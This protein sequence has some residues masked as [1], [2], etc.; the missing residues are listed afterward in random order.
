MAHSDTV[1]RILDAAEELFAEH[2]FSETSLRSITTQA[3]VNLAAVNYHFGSKKALI[4]AVFSRYLSPF[5]K[6]IAGSLDH[7]EKIKPDGVLSIEEML[8]YFVRA[9]AGVSGGDR[10]RLAIFMRLLGLAYNQGQGH[11]RKYLQNEYKTDYERL[12]VL[13]TNA[14][15]DLKPEE[16]FWRFHFMLGSAAFTLSNM[17]HLRAIQKDEFNEQCTEE[18]VLELLQPFLAA[19]IRAAK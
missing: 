11:L 12:M 6:M 9:I 15:P 13:F 19:G 16:R 18:D 3:G 7:Y 4:Q 10:R 8:G 1:T 17:E 5:Y 2:G 14:T